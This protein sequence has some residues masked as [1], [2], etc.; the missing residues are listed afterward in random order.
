MLTNFQTLDHNILKGKWTKPI[1]IFFGRKAFS[2]QTMICRIAVH[3]LS[4]FVLDRDILDC[5]SGIFHPEMA[6]LGSSIA[7]TAVVNNSCVRRLLTKSTSDQSS[8][9]S[10]IKY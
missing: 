4:H 6:I 2:S 8:P 1:T 3:D 9:R 10:E 7:T 5:S